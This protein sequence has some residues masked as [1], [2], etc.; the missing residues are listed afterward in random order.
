MFAR[1]LHRITRL[2][3]GR[4]PYLDTAEC[5]VPVCVAGFH[6]ASPKWLITMLQPS[7]CTAAPKGWETGHWNCSFTEQ[8]FYCKSTVEVEWLLD[9]KQN[10]NTTVHIEGWS[11]QFPQKR[12]T[13]SIHDTRCKWT[14]MK[15]ATKW[16]IYQQNLTGVSEIWQPWELFLGQK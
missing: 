4:P 12:L 1:M 2:L 7:I 10:V 9:S 8:C 11:A 14:G 16:G 6:S 13:L 3:P 5:S 15:N